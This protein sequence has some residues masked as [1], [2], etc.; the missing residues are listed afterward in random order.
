MRLSIFE[1]SF[2]LLDDFKDDGPPLRIH[3]ISINIFQIETAHDL[4]V[5]NIRINLNLKIL[6]RVYHLN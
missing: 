5:I 6:L 4:L 1:K 3:K 2:E